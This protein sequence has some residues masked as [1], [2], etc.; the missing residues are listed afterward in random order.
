MDRE[1]AATAAPDREFAEAI[2]SLPPKVADFLRRLAAHPEFT[3][4]PGRMQMMIHHQ[5]GKVGGLN[6]RLSHWYIS[7]VFVKNRGAERIMGAHRFRHVIK[8]EGHQYW[9][10]EGAGACTAFESALEEM[11]G[12]RLS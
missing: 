4:T 2:A 12:T 8:N 6:R 5:G 10:L 7:K 1:T 9:C 11:T 3:C